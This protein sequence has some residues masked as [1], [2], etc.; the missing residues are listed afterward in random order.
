MAGEEYA[1]AAVRELA[2]DEVRDAVP[3]HLRAL[4][5]RQMIE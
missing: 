4:A 2:A 5:G 3:E 1:A